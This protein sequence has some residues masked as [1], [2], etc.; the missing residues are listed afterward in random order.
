[1]LILLTQKHGCLRKV[2]RIKQ[3]QTA[4]VISKFKSYETFEK[5]IKNFKICQAPQYMSSN[6]RTFKYS[7][8]TIQ[9]FNIFSFL[10][11]ILAVR[12]FKIKNAN[13]SYFL[14]SFGLNL[15]IK[16]S[17]IFESI[18]YHLRMRVKDFFYYCDNF[19][20]LKLRSFSII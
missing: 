5:S 3:S 15:I 18:K 13:F 17:R 1:M 14:F 4:G 9:I 8:F 10:C 19:F 11:F 20:F 6:E 7:I 16:L 12:Y 2:R